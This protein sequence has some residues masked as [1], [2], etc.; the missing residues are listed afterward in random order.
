[1]I[2]SLQRQVCLAFVLLSLMFIFL[3]ANSLKDALSDSHHSLVHLSIKSSQI[4]WQLNVFN[5]SIA[6]LPTFSYG[7]FDLTPILD[8]ALKIYPHFDHIITLLICLNS[9]F[10]DFSKIV[11]SDFQYLTFSHA[12]LMSLGH[13]SQQDALLSLDFSIIQA[14]HQIHSHITAVLSLSLPDISGC[15]HAKD[16]EG[17]WWDAFCGML[18]DLQ[19]TFKDCTKKFETLLPQVR[20][21]D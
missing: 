16:H 10:H 5:V 13:S 17:H 19:V 2:A 12:V 21:V 9:S 8:V 11:W 3:K 4:L 20:Q 1:M 14:L 7:I 15:H 6:S 18:L